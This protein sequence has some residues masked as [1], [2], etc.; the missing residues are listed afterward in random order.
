MVS[1]L[2]RVGGWEKRLPGAAGVAL[3]MRHC[4]V[5]G[6]LTG[7]GVRLAGGWSEQDKEEKRDVTCCDCGH[8]FDGLE[9]N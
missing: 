4:G 9:A 8:A 3:M 2:G 1:C 5:K 7:G 6:Y